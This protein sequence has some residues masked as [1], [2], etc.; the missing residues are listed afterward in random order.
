MSKTYTQLR[1]LCG[2]LEDDSVWVDK[3]NIIAV[4]TR[5]E[6]ATEESEHTIK[7]LAAERDAALEAENAELRAVVDIYDTIDHLRRTCADCGC[8][9][10]LDE[11]VPHCADGCSEGHDEWIAGMCDHYKILKEAKATLAQ[12]NHADSKEAVR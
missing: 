7:S 6:A 8:A 3:I 9:L 10:E 4:R 5:L 1:T 12:S 11:R 2:D